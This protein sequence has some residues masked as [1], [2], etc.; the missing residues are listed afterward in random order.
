MV[1]N[2]ENRENGL[3]RG[4]PALHLSISERNNNNNACETLEKLSVKKKCYSHTLLFQFPK[5]IL[6]WALKTVMWLI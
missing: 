2:E 1:P 3:D 4:M 6:N 5:L